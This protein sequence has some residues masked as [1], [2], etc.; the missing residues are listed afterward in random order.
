MTLSMV[1]DREDLQRVRVAVRPDPMW[2]VV[3]ALHKTWVPEPPTPLVGWRQDVDR[4]VGGARR[5]R[6]AVALLRCLVPRQGSIPD[7]LTP[8][9]PVTELDTGCEAIRGTPPPLLA[10]DLAAVFA[11]RTP[12]PL[13]RSLAR[14]ESEALGRVVRAVRDAYDLLVGPFWT[15]V[16]D[17]V[18]ADRA[19][20]TRQL[21][22]HGV[23]AVLASLPGVL[24]WDG[25]VL[26]TRYPVDRTVRL[27]GR[28]LVLVPSYF[29]WHNPITWIDAELP[30]VLV[31]QAH[32]G[33]VDTGADE[34]LLPRGLTS[35]LGRTRAECL[36]VLLVPSTTTEL[37][38]RLGTSVGTASR[39][40][41]ILRE[42]GLVASNRRGTSVLHT[43]TALG[44][45]LLVGRPVVR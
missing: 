19:R 34:V 39:Q 3:S 14:G 7:F 22:E 2:E 27:A 33:R 20:R 30:P 17:V 38:T 9:G 8:P 31:H 29:C 11:H 45:A 4:R 37:A 36:R 32:T 35:L 23:G 6:E 13:A 40:A 43:T 42:T 12:P 28:G 10:A 1:F 25:H 15:R 26:R 16:C 41:A 44:T 24:G 18:S 21:A 5:G